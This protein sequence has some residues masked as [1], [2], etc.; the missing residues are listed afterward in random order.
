MS[1][2]KGQATPGLQRGGKNREKTTQQEAWAL[3][4]VA[5]G[6]AEAGQGQTQ[7]ALEE[8]DPGCHPFYPQAAPP[9]TAEVGAPAVGATSLADQRGTV[10]GCAYVFSP[11][12]N[13]FSQNRGLQ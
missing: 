6:G 8:S 9:G 4:P 13:C 5:W 3:Q 10:T 2:R 1:G 11:T 12:G 7:E